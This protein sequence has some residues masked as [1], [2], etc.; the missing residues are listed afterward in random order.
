M[1][2]ARI[3]GSGGGARGAL[4]PWPFSCPAWTYK[5]ILIPEIGIINHA[6]LLYS[7]VQKANGQ[8][9]ENSYKILQLYTVHCE[10]GEEK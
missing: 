8:I 5:T 10:E 1:G 7:E 2:V 4:P 9:E 3:G 6:F